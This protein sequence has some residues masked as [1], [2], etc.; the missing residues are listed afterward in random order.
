MGRSVLC[1][2][3]LATFCAYTKAEQKQVHGRQGYVLPT[4][5]IG[6]RVQMAECNLAS[7]THEGKIILIKIVT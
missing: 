4:V 1:W 2:S 5:F 7:D 3:G 6:F